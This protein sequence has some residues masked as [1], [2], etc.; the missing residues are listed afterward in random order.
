MYFVKKCVRGYLFGI[1]GN[2]IITVYLHLFMLLLLS[3]I[4][5][6]VT[7]LSINLKNN[8]KHNYISVIMHTWL[9][10]SPEISNKTKV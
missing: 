10:W 5:Y 8:D 6:N 4:V 3:E 1:H 9:L 2:M 7:L